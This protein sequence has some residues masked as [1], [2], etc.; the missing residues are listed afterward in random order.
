MHSYADRY[1]HD[2]FFDR[3]Y[4]DP[5][6]LQSIY[7]KLTDAPQPKERLEMQVRLDPEVV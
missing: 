3:D 2:F 6:V 4:P 7:D 5:A 1:T